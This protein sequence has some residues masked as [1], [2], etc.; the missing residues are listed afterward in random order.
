MHAEDEF[1]WFDRPGPT[2]IVLSL[3]LEVVF[4]ASGGPKSPG[5]RAYHPHHQR[6]PSNEASPCATPIDDYQDIPTIDDDDDDCLCPAM[7]TK[8][9][10]HPHPGQP[11]TSLIDIGANRRHTQPPHT[12]RVCSAPRKSISAAI[13]A[14]EGLWKARRATT[15]TT[16]KTTTA[17]TMGAGEASL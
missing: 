16:K 5:W 8:T 13:W 15:T 6:K 14:R 1:C 11:S 7:G 17:T 9:A 2:Q 12:T 10:P 3:S 4:R